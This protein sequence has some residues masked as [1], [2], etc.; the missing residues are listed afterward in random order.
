MTDRR[1]EAA[2]PRQRPGQAEKVDDG[3]NQDATEVPGSE[4]GQITADGRTADAVRLVDL[5]FED[6]PLTTY[7][8]R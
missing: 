5:A 6:E 7:R 8:P 3:L 1:R 2:A 4:P